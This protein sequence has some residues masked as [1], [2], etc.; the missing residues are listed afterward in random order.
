MNKLLDDIINNKRKEL[1]ELYNKVSNNIISESESEQ[2]FS[3]LELL[4]KKLF[5]LLFGPERYN[6]NVHN[7]PFSNN[8]VNNCFG[9]LGEEF[10]NTL[11]EEYAYK[12]AIL[13]SYWSHKPLKAAYLPTSNQRGYY[14]S[15]LFYKGERWSDNELFDNFYKFF[16]DVKKINDGVVP[17]DFLTKKCIEN[18]IQYITIKSN[19]NLILNYDPDRN[20]L[21]LPNLLISN[22]HKSLKKLLKFIKECKEY[23]NRTAKDVDHYRDKQNFKKEYEDLLNESYRYYKNTKY[24]NTWTRNIRKA[25]PKSNFTTEAVFFLII[26]Y[27]FYD[28]P[29]NIYLFLPL[30]SSKNKHLLSNLVITGKS[31]NVLEQEHVDLFIKLIEVV[32][33]ISIYEEKIWK[34]LGKNMP[35]YHN[36]KSEFERYQEKYEMLKNIA[37]NVCFSVCADTKVKFHAIPARIKSFNSF[38][39]KIVDRANGR[40]ESVKSN[41]IEFYHNAV[42]EIDIDAIVDELKDIVGVRIICI[43]NSDVNKI[44]DRLKEIK[45]RDLKRISIKTNDDDK[46]KLSK[47]VVNYRSVHFVF[48]IGSSRRRILEFKNL[49][50]LSFEIQVRSILAHGWADVSHELFYKS[51]LAEEQLEK[52]FN[53]N[54]L[55]MNTAAIKLLEI[56]NHFDRFRENHNNYSNK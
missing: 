26:S 10:H 42:K 55:D 4:I 28:I 47:D 39:N 9:L 34:N 21:L 51:G 1:R 5:H 53:E 50:N 32:K 56:D 25:F 36:W 38:Y 49:T 16:N 23:Y 22:K 15:N 27:Q 37:I 43:Y 41:E 18:R 46:F 13:F 3:E 52:F 17:I 7:H 6:N 20:L 48:R 12:D 30:L 11:S 35:L 44:V 31:E 14:R 2:L 45:T 19:Q 8:S 33:N 24:L 54:N 29:Y 40:D